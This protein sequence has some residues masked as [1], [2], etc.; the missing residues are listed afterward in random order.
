MNLA[1]LAVAGLVVGLGLWLLVRQARQRQSEAPLLLAALPLAVVML[2]APIPLVALWTIDAFS[3]IGSTGTATQTDAVA[4]ADQM[5]RPLWWGAVGF[6]LALGAAAWLQRLETLRVG[7]LTTEFPGES[8][9]GRW[10]A[11]AM[12]CASAVVVVPAVFL[13]FRQAELSTL[14]LRAGTILQNPEA[15]AIA[16]MSLEE[17]TQMISRRLIVGTLGGFALLVLVVMSAVLNVVACRFV[18]ASEALLMFS[19]AVFIFTGLFG[20]WAVTTLW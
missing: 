8:P 5:A 9:V 2:V 20:L 7:S 1:P 18:A 11:S 6:L 12:L 17:F 14:I 4:L 16:G 3:S 19:R 15:G 13:F 10:W